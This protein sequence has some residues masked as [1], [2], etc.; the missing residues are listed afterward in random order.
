MHTVLWHHWRRTG[1]ANVVLI[2]WLRLHASDGSTTVECPS[3]HDGRSRPAV[4]QHC[5]DRKIDCVYNQNQVDCTL[6]AQANLRRHGSTIA[7][8]LYS[9]QANCRC[10]VTSSD[11]QRWHRELTSS[12]RL[13]A[14]VKGDHGMDGLVPLELC[15]ALAK[16][17]DFAT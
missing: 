8:L 17:I 14:S 10:M 4:P 6:E 13:L 2:D 3:G 12:A 16:Q 9:S 7:V 5:G 1:A 15:P 11:S